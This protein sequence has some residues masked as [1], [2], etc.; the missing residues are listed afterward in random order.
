[1]DADTQ[2]SYLTIRFEGPEV[3]PGRMRLDDFVQA[4]HEF[5]A[6]AKRVALA[7]QQ[8]PST[9]KGRRPEEIVAALSLDIV[10]FTHGSPAAVAYLERTDGQ[11]LL[12]LADSGDQT[13]RTLI[14]G[15]EVAGGGGEALPLG[16][17][18]GVL[19]KLRDIG[20]LFKKGVSRIEFALNHRAQP[21]KASFDIGKCE[22]I[23]R[24]IEK[25]EGQLQ[26]IQ[27]RLL[28]ADFRETGRQLRIHPPVGPA[29]ICKFPEGLSTEVEECIRQFVRVSGKMEYHPTGEPRWLNIT[30]IEQIDAPSTSALVQGSP[31]W[32]Y[33][34][35][36]NLPAA[37]YARRQGVQP[38]SD[39][40][41]L[42]GAGAAED[43]EGFDEAVERWRAENPVIKSAHPHAR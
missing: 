13:Y 18:L 38:V 10:G 6:C 9:V 29:L 3:K 39:F 14:E 30:D 7:L 19:M 12:E 42:F 15:I 41:A 28:M 24:R 37:E 34:Y 36:E 35:G 2:N 31:G 33:D 11:M 26:T 20:K 16:F 4:A 27:G 40:S 21:V 25:P 43:W 32:R 23:R 5:S 1:M 8:T 17:D 22:R